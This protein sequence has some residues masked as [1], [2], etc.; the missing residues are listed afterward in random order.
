MPSTLSSKDTKVADTLKNIADGKIQLPDFQRGW[1]WDDDRIR[2]LIASISNMYPVGAVMVMCYGT[3]SVQF[4]YRPFEGSSTTAVP[5]RLVLDGQQRLTSLFNATYCKEPVK[6]KTDKGKEVERLY[7]LDIEK[8]LS[9]TTDRIDAIISVNADKTLREN[10]DRDIVLDLRTDKQE[11]SNHMFPLNIVYDIRAALTWLR[12]YEDYHQGNIEIK[13]QS[14]EFET[15]ILRIIQDYE[16]P[17]ISLGEETPKEAICQIFEN[18]NQGGVRLTAFELMTASFA[19]DT[20]VLATLEDGWNLRDDWE[21]RIAYMK[22][23]SRLLNG[24]ANTDFLTSL[25][26]LVNYYKKNGGEGV[27][28]TKKDVLQLSLPEYLQYADTLCDAFVKTARLLEEQ[29]IFK[30]RDLPYN[31]QLIPLSSIFAQLGSRSH[32]NPVRQKLVRWY[33]CGV[34]GEMYGGAN[35]T[36]YARDMVGVLRW[37][38]GSDEPDTIRSAYFQP[39][40]LLTLQSRQSAAYKGIMALI[41][42]AGAL[43]FISGRAMD[44]TAFIDEDIDIHHIFPRAYCEGQGLKRERWNSIVN[45]TPL[46]GK[47]NRIIQGHAPSQY[48]KRLVS[49]SDKHVEVAELES[50]VE[51]HRIDVS[52]LR[53]DDFSAFFISRAKALID[54]IGDA[55]GKQIS[56]LN[57]Q[58]VI[59]GFGG[60]LE[61]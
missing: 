61:M 50:F 23:K 18:V 14:R 19:A 28:C 2:A 15:S 39:T 29:R 5:E 60:V 58:E 57:T 21:K 32:D 10:F 52:E 1:V 46:S 36:R 43:D 22:D 38:N 30:S 44:F 17:V 40:R 42:K 6:T 11:F 3:R 16:I 53:A 54:L 25:T 24:V 59:D 26:L 37:V 20:A 47:S 35:E 45:K 27:S 55:M 41:L 7:Y 12:D 48:L 8:C 34:L 56:N 51:T 49:S 31:T 13:E 9:S 4:K 33:W